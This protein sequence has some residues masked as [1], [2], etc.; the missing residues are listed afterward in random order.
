MNPVHKFHSSKVYN[1]KISRPLHSYI[2]GVTVRNQWLGKTK[3]ED[4]SE[5]TEEDGGN[6]EDGWRYGDNTD[7]EETPDGD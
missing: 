7:D 5:V 1:G 4:D 6:I 2:S 3:Y